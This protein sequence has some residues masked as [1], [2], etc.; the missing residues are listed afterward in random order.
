MS[1]LIKGVAVTLYEPALTGE[2]AFGAPVYTETPVT[3]ENVLVSPVS[4]EEVVS[5]ERLYGK[6][7]VYE[8]SLPKGDVHEWEDRRVSF[9]GEDFRAFGFQRMFIEANVPLDWNAKVKVARYG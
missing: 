6:K 3:V 8:L 2:D 4:A 5:A 7:A 1:S 9:F